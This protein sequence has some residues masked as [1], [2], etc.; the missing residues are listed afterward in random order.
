MTRHSARAKWNTANARLA[1]KPFD[2][3]FTYDKPP[4]DL[5]PLFD[6]VKRLTPDMPAERLAERKAAFAE[7]IR[8]GQ[9]DTDGLWQDR[10]G[11]DT[12][13]ASQLGDAG[14]G[15]GGVL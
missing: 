14:F 8:E 12:D 13:M 7:R 1:N 2:N 15:P 11:S 5:M 6:A 3:L 4:A 10:D 9:A